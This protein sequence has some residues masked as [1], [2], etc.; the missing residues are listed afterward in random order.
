MCNQVEVN[1]AMALNGTWP[2]P[3]VIHN[4]AIFR[5]LLFASHTSVDLFFS[6][7]LYVCA[8]ERGFERTGVRRALLLLLGEDE[9]R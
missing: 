7:P 6:M 8:P 4:L 3:D 2:F 1:V 9:M 5:S